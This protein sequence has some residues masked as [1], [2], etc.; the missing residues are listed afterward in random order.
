MSP[1]N[2]IGFSID[3]RKSPTTPSTLLLRLSLLGGGGG[4]GARP[5]GGGGGGGVLLM[6]GEVGA[7]GTVSH[8]RW[9]S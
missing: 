6:E 7:V 5:G 9:S 2:V 4:G 3:A 1:E 8:A